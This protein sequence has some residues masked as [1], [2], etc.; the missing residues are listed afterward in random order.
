[1]NVPVRVLRAPKVTSMSLPSAPVG[2]YLTDRAKGVTLLMV[3]AF[4]SCIV[5]GMTFPLVFRGVGCGTPC[6]NVISTAFVAQLWA[7]AGAFAI[8]L[9]AVI[10]LSAKGRQ[11]WRVPT[12]GTVLVLGVGI[13][14]TIAILA[15]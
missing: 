9:V 6:A 3:Q 14:T 8:S 11:A 4:V 2:P 10:A 1:M 5:V 15:A 13:I 12:V 7:V